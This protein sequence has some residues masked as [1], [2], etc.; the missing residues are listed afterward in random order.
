M[1]QSNRETEY[2]KEPET[3][4]K[5]T[6]TPEQIVAELCQVEVLISQGKTV[7]LACKE[8][9]I[10]DQTHYRWRKEYGGL[11]LEQAKKLKDLQKENAQL[12]R[13]LA[14][15]TLEKQI[16]KDIAEG[17]LR[18]QTITDTRPDAGRGRG[19]ETQRF[20]IVTWRALCDLEPTNP[21]L[22]QPASTRPARILVMIL[23]A[24]ALAAASG[25][26]KELL[27]VTILTVLR[28]ES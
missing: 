8:A 10:V 9:G 20:G 19:A 13:A 3:C 1:Y 22:F 4:Q 5:K 24:I 27:S 7:P 21:M 23:S 28:V 12:K 14:T 18:E 2:G 26:S 11:Q 15:L 16:L 17:G 6:F 25:R